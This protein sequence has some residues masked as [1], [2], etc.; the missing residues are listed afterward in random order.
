MFVDGIERT[1]CLVHLREDV[2]YTSDDRIFMK[3][4]LMD[5]AGTIVGQH[6]HEYGH[7][8]LLVRGKL[9]V[10]ADGDDV[11][12]QYEAPA[13]IW[14][15]AKTKHLF[16]SLEDNTHVYCVHNMKDQETDVPSIFEANEFK[17]GV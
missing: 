9:M 11:G 1:D 14:I 10:F 12:V 4:M 13:F 7:T 17:G 6:A 3:G 2:K 15:P 8:S 5:K 16:S